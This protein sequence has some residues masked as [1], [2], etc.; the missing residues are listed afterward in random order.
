VSGRHVDGPTEAVCEAALGMSTALAA[1][2]MPWALLAKRTKPR[3]SDPTLRRA[4]RLLL[5]AGCIRFQRRTGQWS[6]VVGV[7]LPPSLWP[8]RMLVDVVELA[9]ASE[10][11]PAPDDLALDTPAEL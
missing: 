11:Q 8:R 9:F 4:C 7:T 1:G 3:W 6:R 5:A 10:C 2:S